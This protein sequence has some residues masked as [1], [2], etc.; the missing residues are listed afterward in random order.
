M[1][2]RACFL[3]GAAAL[4]LMLFG[5]IDRTTPEP[6][7]DD[8]N[9][10]AQTS[11]G[12]MAETEEGYYLHILGRLYYADK[13][14]LT[15]WVV[16]CNEPDCSHTADTCPAYFFS[17]F[18][19][20]E[21]RI[22]SIRNPLNFD[23]TEDNCDALYSMALDGT[24][25]RQEFKIE[26]SKGDLGGTG[27][28]Y[29]LEDR[30]LARYS[31]M[32]PDGRFREF[33][34]QIDGEGTHFLYDRQS[35]EANFELFCRASD[36][37][38]MRGDL[39]MYV[40]LVA[41]GETLAHLYRPTASGLEEI[42][43]VCDYDRIGAYLTE[44]R[45]LRFVP[46][47]GYYETDLTTNESRKWEEAQLQDSWAFH[48]TETYI[49]ETNLLAKNDLETPEVRFYDGTAWRS[50]KLPAE[51]MAEPEVTLAPLA[52][53]TE[54]LFLT[55]YPEHNAEL[56]YIPLGADQLTMTLCGMFENN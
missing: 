25:L 28:V 40:D 22:E 14:D 53:T 15:N 31:L 55:T 34:L 9:L 41:G 10:C 16:V 49:L 32:Q 1:K 7:R 5:C 45:L 8:L 44:N 19:L 6:G 36:W 3:L 42:E 39:A 51:L 24:D 48:L 12:I 29:L 2:K 54:G 27:R 52:L 38:P 11:G 35:E 23:R 18:R 20:R 43:N 13:T 37:D 46:N 47:N 30:I 50:V 33:V 21:G 17:E 26:E 56:Y 4:L